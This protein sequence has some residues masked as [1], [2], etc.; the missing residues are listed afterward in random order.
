MIKH[1]IRK[2]A[3]FTVAICALSLGLLP[4]A[5]AGETAKKE[6]KQLSCKQEG[7]KKGIKDKTE[8]KK[9]ISNCEASRK[10][11]K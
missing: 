7:K 1:N 6:T 10:A 2:F 5:Y 4:A 3:F 8:L 11:A 9:Y